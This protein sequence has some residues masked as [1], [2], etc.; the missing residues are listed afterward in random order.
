MDRSFL[1]S[2]FAENSSKSSLLSKFTKTLFVL[3]KLHPFGLLNQITSYSMEKHIFLLSGHYYSY[4]FSNID[5]FTLNPMPQT[6][7][8]RAWKYGRMAYLFGRKAI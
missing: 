5:S 3:E 2:D 6:Q 8:N 4:L 7:W 1:N